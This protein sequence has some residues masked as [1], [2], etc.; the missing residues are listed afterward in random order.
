MARRTYGVKRTNM[1]IQ[2]AIRIWLSCFM[3]LFK[4][5][6][7]VKLTLSRRYDAIISTV[8]TNSVYSHK[9]T[10]SKTTD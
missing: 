1:S 10:E 3:S 5:H 4:T 8:A 9:P 7:R 2:L 6:A